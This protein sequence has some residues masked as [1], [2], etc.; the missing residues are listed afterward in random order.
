MTDKPKIITTAPSLVGDKVYLRPATAEDVLN[1]HHWHLMSEPASMSCRPLTIRNAAAAAEAFKQEECSPN[2]QLFMVV[3]KKDNV[4]VGR[5]RFFD[6]NVH[7]R[8]AEF[9]MLIDPDERKKG[10][11]REAV[12]LLCKYLFDVRGLNKV[13]AQTAEFNSGAIKLL[14]RCGFQKDGT[15][16]RHY[17]HKGEFYDGLIYS[18]L[19]HEFK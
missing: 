15:L 17:F 10:H 12:M 16:R 13:Y 11:A 3:R 14:E 7:N 8:S 5:T 2:R 4:P 18:I 19:Q 1:T 6:L 9:G